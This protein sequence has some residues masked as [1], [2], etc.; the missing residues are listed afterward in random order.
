[1]AYKQFEAARVMIDNTVSATV[2]ATIVVLIILGVKLVIWIK[3]WVRTA[4]YTGLINATLKPPS[5]ELNL[6][7]SSIGSCHVNSDIWL[8]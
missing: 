8:L 3:T 7:I 2:V 6:C 5:F 1:M 4:A